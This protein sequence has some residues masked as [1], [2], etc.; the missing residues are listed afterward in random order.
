MCKFKTGS[1]TIRQKIPNV[2]IGW[3]D[4]E[5]WI[6]YFFVKRHPKKSQ[7]IH[8]HLKVRLK[9]LLVKVMLSMLK[10]SFNNFLN[11]ISFTVKNIKNYTGWVK[12]KCDLRRLVQNCTFFFATLLYG[13]FSIFFENLYFF[14]V[15]QWPPKKSANLFFS[16]NQKFRKGK[17]CIHIISF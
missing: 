6:L 10:N 7:R 8:C 13:V 11:I 17:M 2:C 16:Q 1:Y 15:L 14:L 5:Y 4:H 3:Q 12:K 9:N